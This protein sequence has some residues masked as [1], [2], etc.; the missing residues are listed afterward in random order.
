MKKSINFMLFL[1][2]LGV[3]HQIDG[4]AAVIK[5]E[6]RGIVKYSTVSIAESV[7]IPREGQR[8][9]FYKD[10]KIVTCER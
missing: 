4:D 10:Y 9:F 3:V 2:L 7:C 1:L 8:V 6:K 5:Y